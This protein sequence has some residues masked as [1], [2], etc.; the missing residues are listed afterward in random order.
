MANELKRLINKK[1]KIIEEQKEIQEDNQDFINETKNFNKKLLKIFLIS[2]GLM[3]PMALYTIPIIPT[4]TTIAG[5]TMKGLTPILPKAIP[6]SLLM[7][8]AFLGGM[9]FVTSTLS[10][11]IINILYFTPVKM[12]GKHQETKLTKEKSDINKKIINENKKNTSIITQKK[13]TSKYKYSYKPTTNSYQPTTRR[14]TNNSN[15]STL[16]K[17]EMKKLQERIKKR[18][19]KK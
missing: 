2:C 12:V 4:T 13:Q 15:S 14:T 9:G 8:P 1:N 7:V 10:Y 18:Q 6:V 19:L 11:A 5:V 17:E 16:T 3:I